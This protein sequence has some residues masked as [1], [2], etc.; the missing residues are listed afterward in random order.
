MLS[1]LIDHEAFILAFN[2]ASFIFVVISLSGLILAPF[3]RRA[4]RTL[5]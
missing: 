3:F 5:S 4:R 1:R 2:D